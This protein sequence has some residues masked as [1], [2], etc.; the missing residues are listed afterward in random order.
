VHAAASHRF[1]CPLAACAHVLHALFFCTRRAVC[2]RALCATGHRE[3]TTKKY[4]F[5][6]FFCCMLCACA[7]AARPLFTHAMTS[8]RVASHAK[9]AAPWGGAHAHYTDGQSRSYTRTLKHCNAVHAAPMP[10]LLSSIAHV[11]V[12]A[13]SSIAA[14]ALGCW[15]LLHV[16]DAP[17]ASLHDS[18][19]ER[20]HNAALWTHCTATASALGRAAPQADHAAASRRDF[21]D[22]HHHSTSYVVYVVYDHSL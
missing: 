16:C 19:P 3:T 9:V 15:R 7:S 2:A 10:M 13:Q 12:T 17:H 6:S 21:T 5:F 20:T 18:M 22:R 11:G 1:F 14:C 4:F 8:G